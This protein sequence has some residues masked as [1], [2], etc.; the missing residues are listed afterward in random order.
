MNKKGLGC[1]LC[2]FTLISFVSEQQSF[3]HA[4]YAVMWVVLSCETPRIPS[5][6]LEQSLEKPWADMSLQI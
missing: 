4:G 3:Q 2:L 1:N 6:R 5:N